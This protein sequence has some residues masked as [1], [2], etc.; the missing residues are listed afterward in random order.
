MYRRRRFDP[1][2]LF[3]V[4]LFVLLVAI[5]VGYYFFRQRQIERLA[6]GEVYTRNMCEFW[7]DRYLEEPI[8]CA[9]WASGVAR[10][11]TG[12]VLLCLSAVPYEEDTTWPAESGEQDIFNTCMFG[13]DVIPR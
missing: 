2:V 6:D 9:E 4:G 12:D 5:V 11:R 3:A 7:N 10:S 1:L 8:D 13:R